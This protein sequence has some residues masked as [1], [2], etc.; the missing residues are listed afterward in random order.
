M[1]VIVYKSLRRNQ[2]KTYFHVHSSIHRNVTANFL[3]FT[4]VTSN[5]LKRLLAVRK[6]STDRNFPQIVKYTLVYKSK[7]DSC[8]VNVFLII[9]Q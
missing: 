9:L 2:I 1:L 8:K 4:V 3:W 6:A 5:I 7:H